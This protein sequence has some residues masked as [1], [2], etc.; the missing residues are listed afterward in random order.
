MK[1]PLTKGAQVSAL[2]AGAA[3]P[4]GVSS[5][6]EPTAAP[7]RKTA[8]AA[9]TRRAISARLG[10]CEALLDKFARHVF[11]ALDENRTASSGEAQ[12]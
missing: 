4:E 1:I 5:L 2:S 7:F 9:R 3:R 11:E 6:S 12:R 10:A 8:T